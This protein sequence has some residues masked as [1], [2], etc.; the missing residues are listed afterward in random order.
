MRPTEKSRKHTRKGHSK[1]FLIPLINMYAMFSIAMDGLDDDGPGKGWTVLPDARPRAE[2][3][4]Y[5]LLNMTSP[6]TSMTDSDQ[7]YH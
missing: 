5:L 1:E 7:A 6:L 4:C 2:V 3:I